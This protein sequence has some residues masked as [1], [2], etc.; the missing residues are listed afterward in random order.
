MEILIF[1]LIALFGVVI[2]FTAGGFDSDRVEMEIKA[3]G[4]KLL[5]K[6][7]QPFGKGWLGA[8]N[9]RIQKIHYLDKDG[10]EHEAFVKTSAFSG[11]YFSDDKIVKYAQD[12]KSTKKHT[13]E[14]TDENER[15]KAEISEL[16]KQ[17][18]R[19]QDEEGN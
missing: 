18:A 15:L 3:Q 9:E 4:G 7:W 5:S 12:D 16:K 19:G 6:E 8:N 1:V 14:L 17:L 10:N 11:V 2:S 13:D